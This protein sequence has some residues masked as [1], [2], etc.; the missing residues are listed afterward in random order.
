M[1][2][3]YISQNIV[4]WPLGYPFYPPLIFM[5]G[6]KKDRMRFQNKYEFLRISERA[7]KICKFVKLLLTTLIVNP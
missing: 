1:V 6:I 2:F 5:N 4:D 3:C 7:V